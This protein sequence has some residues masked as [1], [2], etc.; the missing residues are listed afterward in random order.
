MYCK[1]INKIVVVNRKDVRLINM[2][3]GLQEVMLSKISNSD[4]ELTFG[5]LEDNI[6]IVSD[7]DGRL[8]QIDVMKCE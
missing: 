5:T 2:Q 7:I 8:Y 4:C 1:Q 3:D 6:L